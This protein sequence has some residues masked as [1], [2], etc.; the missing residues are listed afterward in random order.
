MVKCYDFAVQK[1]HSEH[2]LEWHMFNVNIG[3]SLLGLSAINC[4]G[5]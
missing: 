1:Q 4:G 2:F 3:V 5:S